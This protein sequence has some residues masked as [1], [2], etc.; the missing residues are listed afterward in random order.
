MRRQVLYAHRP[1]LMS[2]NSRLKKGIKLSKK[3]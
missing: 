1:M 3:Y 2:N